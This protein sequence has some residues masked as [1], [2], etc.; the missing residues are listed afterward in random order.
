M[1][2]S[3]WVQSKMSAYTERKSAQSQP[4]TSFS[5]QFTTTL[6]AEHSSSEQLAPT[7]SQPLVKLSA[8]TKTVSEVSDSDALAGGHSGWQ[9]R[10][11]DRPEARRDAK[12]IRDVQVDVCGGLARGLVGVPVHER[13][14]H[15]RAV[16]TGRAAVALWD[17]DVSLEFFR[18]RR[19]LT[20][21]QI[22]TEA[23][24]DGRSSN[25]MTSCPN[26]RKRTYAIPSVTGPLN[27]MSVLV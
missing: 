12:P 22:T 16:L 13:E 2:R 19:E 26:C 7:P 9:W 20:C 25:E 23:I 1:V 15:R 10:G 3:T 6:A 18:S 5:K 24:C 8:D 21:L 11:E 27:T 14:M 4:P 17:I